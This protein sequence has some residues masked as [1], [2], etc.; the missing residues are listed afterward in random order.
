MSSLEAAVGERMDKLSEMKSKKQRAKVRLFVDPT[1]TVTALVAVFTSFVQFKGCSCLESLVEP[2]PEGPVSFGW[3]TNPA[4]AWLTKVSGLLFDLLAVAKNS[5]LASTKVTRALHVMWKNRDLTLK[6][7]K[8]TTPSDCIDRIDFMVRVLMNQLRTLKVNACLRTKVWRSLSREDQCRLD[9]V[10]ERLQLPKELMQGAEEDDED[11]V[12]FT[13][14][15]LLPP[16]EEPLPL[17]TFE[18]KKEAAVKKHKNFDQDI[19]PA[20]SVFSTIL[21][22]AGP[23]KVGLND[24]KS[25]VAVGS[26]DKTKKT[27]V[28]NTSVESMFKS[29]L[30]IAMKHT[31]KITLTEPKKAAKKQQNSSKKAKACKKTKV[32][33]QKVAQKKTSPKKKDVQYTSTVKQPSGA[34]S[35]ASAVSEQEYQP[36][37][38][39]EERAK[40]ITAWLKDQEQKG[41]CFSRA[42]ALKE[43]GTSLKKAQLLASVPLTELKRRRFV[44]KEAET[45]PF[46][47]MVEKAAPQDVD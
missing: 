10:L 28:R 1:I 35:K 8:H 45:N 19:K 21:H 26:K 27:A 40:W 15:N 30:S 44:G 2:P 3:H 11:E 12:K 42:H 7:N 34:S 36:G 47:E 14:V 4:P 39:L 43:W 9:M 23:A 32:K 25:E 24:L 5:K 37:K 22:G 29:V 33:K 18:K 41:L 46:L 13:S 38:F 20:P 6:T 31:P 16:P 17:V